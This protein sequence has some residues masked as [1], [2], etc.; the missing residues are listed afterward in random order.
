MFDNIVMQMK[1]TLQQ[2]HS[3]LVSEKAEIGTNL[4][5]VW[6]HNIVYLY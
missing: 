5:L 4:S 3:L 2:H 1:M 6:S